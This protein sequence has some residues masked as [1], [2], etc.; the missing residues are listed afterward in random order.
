[1]QLKEYRDK[2]KK[3]PTGYAPPT[4][5]SPDVLPEK[6]QTLDQQYGLED[7]YEPE[8]DQANQTIEQE[9]QSYVTGVLS[10]PGTNMIKY[11]DVRIQ[12]SFAL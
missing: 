8:A 11:W 9:Y 4:S 10:K 3:T 7:M 5:Q 1:M 6:W 12:Y 2:A